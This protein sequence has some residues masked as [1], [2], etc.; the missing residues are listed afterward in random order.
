MPNILGVSVSAASLTHLAFRSDQLKMPYHGANL[1]V[2]AVSDNGP[3]IHS[4]VA[5]CMSQV[6]SLELQTRSE[7]CQHVMDHVVHLTNLG[8]LV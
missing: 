7:D 2:S 8:R 1:N 3:G 6:T 4:S 5:A